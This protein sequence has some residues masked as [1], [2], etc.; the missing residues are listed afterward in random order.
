MA[1]L[2]HDKLV[3][4]AGKRTTVAG[5][6]HDPV[7]HGPHPPDVGAGQD[8]LAASKLGPQLCR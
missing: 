6:Q 2:A 4:A 5:M 1:A 7:R 3:A 8:V